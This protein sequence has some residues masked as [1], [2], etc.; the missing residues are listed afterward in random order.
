MTPTES[1]PL[2]QYAETARNEAFLAFKDKIGPREQ[3]VLDLLKLGPSTGF[4]LASRL[5][6][7]PYVVR[8]RISA[9]SR[10]DEKKQRP[11][12]I[13]EC[14][15]KSFEDKPRETIWRLK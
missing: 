1:L 5:G 14:G 15:I 10:P 7:H 13:E 6:R 12:L 2:F 9:L 8:P 4:E 3:E 11:A